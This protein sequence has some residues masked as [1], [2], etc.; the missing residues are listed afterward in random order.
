M[1]MLM[2]ML[3]LALTPE[4]THFRANDCPSDGHF[5]NWSDF[6]LLADLT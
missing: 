3:M 1:L 2:L 5:W 4:V 6:I